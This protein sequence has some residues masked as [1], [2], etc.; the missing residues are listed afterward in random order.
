MVELS[1][2]SDNRDFC[3]E[4]DRPP[5]MQGSLQQLRV[6]KVGTAAGSMVECLRSIVNRFAHS[7]IR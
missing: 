2:L 4:S 5:H 3:K 1:F 6:K 7:R